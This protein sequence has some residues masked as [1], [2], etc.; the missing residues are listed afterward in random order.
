MGQPKEVETQP[1][2]VQPGVNSLTWE[3]YL[4]LPE[5]ARRTRGERALQ[6]L[7]ALQGKV[8]VNIDIDELRGRSRR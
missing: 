3:Q 5:A 6:K 1:D 8:H 2:E 4:A 7:R